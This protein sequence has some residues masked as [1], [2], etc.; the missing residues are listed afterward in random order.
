MKKTKK[1]TKRLFIYQCDKL[2]KCKTF[3]KA[4]QDEETLS[5]DDAE[6]LTYDE[7]ETLTYNEAA[8]NKMLICVRK[9]A[10]DFSKNGC[11]FICVKRRKKQINYFPLQEKFIC[12][13]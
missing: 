3:A 7:A 8:T 5:H 13:I 11:G 2:S 12:F 1:T 6:T 9:K 10:G 4:A